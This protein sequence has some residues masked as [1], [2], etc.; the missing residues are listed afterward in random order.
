MI[1]RHYSSLKK[2]ILYCFESPLECTQLEKY[3]FMFIEQA[4]MLHVYIEI[5]VLENAPLQKNPSIQEAFKQV[6]H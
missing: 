6:L 3:C 5:L 4:H 1:L 2:I